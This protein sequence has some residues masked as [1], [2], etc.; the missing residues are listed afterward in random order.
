MDFITWPVA[1]TIIGLGIAFLSFLYRMLK[2]DVTLEDVKRFKEVNEKIESIKS[3][4]KDNEKDTDLIEEHLKE[5]DVLHKT[6]EEKLDLIKEATQN[7]KKD[8]EA[9]TDRQNRMEDRVKDLLDK[10]ID[11]I[12]TTK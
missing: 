5:D 2:K 7:N 11:L 4:I 6:L 1:F 12:K 9:V 8:I 3:K 10:F